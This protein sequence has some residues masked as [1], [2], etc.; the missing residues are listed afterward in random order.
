MPEQ[1]WTPKQLAFALVSA[2]DGLVSSGVYK[3]IMSLGDADRT[4][5]EAAKIELY[6]K[7]GEILAEVLC[8]A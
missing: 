1:R 7:A 6:N 2:Q 4:A 8:D 5:F 3:A